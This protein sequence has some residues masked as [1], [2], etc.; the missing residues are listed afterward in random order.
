MTTRFRVTITRSAQNEIAKLYQ[1]LVGNAAEDAADRLVD[2]LLTAAGSLEEFA[3]RGAV[4]S[5]IAP[6]PE[7]EVR[8]LIVGSHR[9][10]YLVEEGEVLVF[11]IVDGRSDVGPILRQ[12]LGLD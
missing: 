11:L 7:D 1:Y 5:E 4:P 2:A 8:Q 10:I 6:V 12:R 9:L 3:R